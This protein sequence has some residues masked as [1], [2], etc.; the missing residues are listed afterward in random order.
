LGKGGASAQQASEV[1]Y[2]CTAETV[3]VECTEE[4]VLA[5]FDV[6]LGGQHIGEGFVG[7]FTVEKG[8]VAD[9]YIYLLGRLG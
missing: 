5:T 8:R 2:V 6:V 4:I 3:I 1:F 9:G 7:I